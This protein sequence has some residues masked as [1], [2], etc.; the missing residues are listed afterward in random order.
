MLLYWAIIVTVL[1]AALFTMIHPFM[2]ISTVSPVRNRDGVTRQLKDS[3]VLRI[4]FV[5]SWD[6][7]PEIELFIATF[8]E[9]ITTGSVEYE[10]YSSDIML[11]QGII[12]HELLTDNSYVHIDLGDNK[13][14]P[15]SSCYL[16]LRIRNVS[17]P[18]ALWSGT[19]EKMTISASI[20]EEPLTGTPII[21]FHVYKADWVITWDLFMLFS[22]LLL[23]AVY[24]T[25]RNKQE[26]QK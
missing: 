22:I 20:N 13:I 12:P 26:V 11:A 17:S 24:L 10:F 14:V 6:K 21:V 1:V 15:E 25:F 16:I 9:I 18:I 4:D 7:I 8:M 2:V 3:D 5:S 19:V 23:P